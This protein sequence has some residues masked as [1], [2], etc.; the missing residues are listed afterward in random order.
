MNL[1]A[2][3]PDD[4]HA[5]LALWREAAA[6]PSVSDDAA[7]VGALLERDRGSLILAFDDS[8]ELVG[9]IVAAWDGWRGH[10]YRLAV[11]PDRRRSGVATTLVSA[12]EARLRSFGARKI[13]G[14]VLADNDVAQAFWESN[15]YA[16]DATVVRHAKTFPPT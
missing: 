2:A 7:G 9:T 13:Q 12:A 16:H 1:R 3:T 14:I 8:G 6:A 4:I 10:V 15:G 11:R 5:V